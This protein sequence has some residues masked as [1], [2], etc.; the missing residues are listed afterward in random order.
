MIT[1]LGSLLGLAVA[2]ETVK[3]PFW[4]AW[5]LSRM[6]RAAAFYRL[7]AN[8]AR[9]YGFGTGELIEEEAEHLDRMVKLAGGEDHRRAKRLPVQWRPLPR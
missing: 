4:K 7:Q 1:V 3:R 2:V 5:Q 8:E 6:R 9:L